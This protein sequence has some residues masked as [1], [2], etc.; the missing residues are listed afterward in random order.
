MSEIFA[1][2]PAEFDPATVEDEFRRLTAS[3]EFGALSVGRP[4]NWTEG[5]SDA[6]GGNMRDGD[7]DGDGTRNNPGR[8]E[9]D[10]RF[11]D[12]PDEGRIINPEDLPD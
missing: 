2:A 1:P 11:E 10:P 5:Q 3:L 6:L 4:Q 7:I 12:D 9:D 8:E